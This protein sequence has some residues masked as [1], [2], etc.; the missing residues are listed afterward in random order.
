MRGGGRCLLDGGAKR[1]TGRGPVRRN[2]P[3]GR[4]GSRVAEIG[5]GFIDDPLACWQDFVTCGNF[6]RAALPFVD[7]S[8]I[9][10]C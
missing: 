10:N 5:H 1:A 6:A 4:I 9:V 8:F 2:A 3:S 7:R